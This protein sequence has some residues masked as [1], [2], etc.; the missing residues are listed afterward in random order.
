MKKVKKGK[1]SDELKEYEE[2]MVGNFTQTSNY[3]INS[4]G[5]LGLNENEFLFLSYLQQWIGLPNMRIHDFQ[6]ARD[7]FWSHGKI[8][9][10]RKALVEKHLIAAEYD[11]VY[12]PEVGCKSNGYRYSLN[13]LYEK[14]I[15][16]SK[17]DS[18]EYN[19]MKS[20]S[21]LVVSEKRKKDGRHNNFKSN[22]ST[23]HPVSKIE[24]SSTENRTDQYQGRSSN[25]TTTTLLQNHINILSSGDDNFSE[26]VGTTEP[27]ET[28]GEQQ[29]FE[30][31]KHKNNELHEELVPPA[32][33]PDEII[34]MNSDGQPEPD[35]YY[36]SPTPE[37]IA[38]EERLQKEYEEQKKPKRPVDIT[39]YQLP[40]DA[41][42][43][44]VKA[45][46]W[47]YFRKES[48]DAFKYR[49][50]LMSLNKE[51]E[52]HKEVLLEA[53]SYLHDYW[54]NEWWY[55]DGSL[56]MF[57]MN[58]E[59]FASTISAYRWQQLSDY[60]EY[61]SDDLVDESIKK[62]NLFDIRKRRKLTA[63]IVAVM[64]ND[65]LKTISDVQRLWLT[66]DP[67]KL[68]YNAVDCICLNG[69]IWGEKI[70]PD[71]FDEITPDSISKMLEENGYVKVEKKK[72]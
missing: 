39:K 59:K 51:L 7:L 58:F 2:L 30:T 54:N 62:N 38:E 52:D 64:E 36:D 20:K 17:M 21:F 71:D 18:D 61:F 40:P 42:L 8:F 5:I 15:G 41:N 44:V 33:A 69:S 47:D 63:Q 37:D 3:F 22:K 27:L 65:E 53:I 66:A 68:L 70:R 55:R 26:S 34:E 43:E 50:K 67:D 35:H 23:D 24:L 14:V 45:K 13:G 31:D 9:N 48:V 19:M 4:F 32:I 6:I 46:I 12:T 29:T 28:E 10:T 56:I 57:L 49:P 11:T 72:D 16:Y 1:V 25:N 60:C